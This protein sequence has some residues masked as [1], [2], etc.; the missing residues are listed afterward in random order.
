R[1]EPPEPR[2]VY[3]SAVDPLNLAG[4]LTP[5]PRVPAQA[6]NVMALHGGAVAGSLQGGDVSIRPQLGPELERDIRRVLASRRIPW[7]RD[8]AAD[9]VPPDGYSA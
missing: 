1:R 7:P 6:G 2:L 3:L 9:T 8:D 4:I 5:G